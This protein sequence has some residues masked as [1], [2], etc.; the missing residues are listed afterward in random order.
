MR[1]IEKKWAAGMMIAAWMMAGCHSSAPDIRHGALPD[2]NAGPDVDAG[3]DADAGLETPDWTWET[4]GQVSPHYDQVFGPDVLNFFIVISPENWQILQQDMDEHLQNVQMGPGIDLSAWDPVFVPCTLEANGRTWYQVGIRVKGNSSLVAAYKS[5][6]QKFSFKLDFDEF[7]DVWPQIR[8]QRFY[9]FKQLNL[10]NNFDDPGQLHEHLGMQLMQAAGLAAPRTR[11]ATLTLDAGDGPRYYGVYTL[12]EEPDDTLVKTSFADGNLYK[13]D[14]AAATFAAG[15]W[16]EAGYGKENHENAA[17]F[18]DVRAL[19]DALHSPD[20]LTAPE[21]WR[22]QLEAAFDVD[23]F[24]TWLAA[25]TVTQNGDSYG[26]AP[27][28][29]ILRLRRTQAG[30]SGFRGT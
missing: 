19:Y 4:H 6:I 24:L 1:T 12:V 23:A 18:S 21:T 28:N 22:A 29:Y 15:T 9:G 27:H 8:D 5:G 26:M 11:L 17:D 30:L 14:G 2:A 20:R 13:P 7:E 16:D 10:K 3:P 25:N